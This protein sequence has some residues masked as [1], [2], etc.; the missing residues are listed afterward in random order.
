MS[1]VDGLP[2]PDAMLDPTATPA[3]GATAF[4]ERAAALRA[5]VG[6]A[7]GDAA[8]LVAQLSDDEL[9]GLLDGDAG[10]WAGG[11]RMGLRGY[12]AEPIVAGAVP[13]LGIPGIRFTDGPR[14]IVMG[15]STCF[16]VAIARGATWDPDLEEE[17]GR[18]IGAEGRAQGANFFGGVCINL[19]RHPAWGRAQETYGEDTYHLGVMGSALARGVGTEL[20]ACAKHFALNSIECARFVVDVEADERS[21][22][23]VYLPHFRT[24]VESG[25]D[26]V[27]SAY[28]SVNGEWC[29]DSGT[30]LTAILREEWGFEGLVVSDFAF[31]LR[32]PVGSV[33]AGLDLEMPFRQ[34]RARALPAALADGRLDREDVVRCATRIL[35]AQLRY[36][37]RIQ[38]P[39]PAPAVVASG[40]H[41][42]L[43]R[44]AAAQSMVLLRDEEVDGA[45]LLPLDPDRLQRM[46]VLGRLAT[47]R[48]LGDEGSSAVRP[49]SSVTILD[50]IRA[51]FGAATE[52]EHD[53]GDDVGR[54]AALASEAEVAV[55]TVGYGA[56]DEGEAI[57]ARMDGALRT[58]PPPVG[59]G[60]VAR[61]A[62]RLVGWVA[63][64]PRTP[65]GDRRRL[66]LHPEDERLIEAV[67]AANPRTVVVVIGGSAVLMERWRRK[68]AAILLAWYPGMEGGH[69]LVE[70]LAGDSEPGGRLPFV[71]PTDEAHLPHF[72]RDALSITYDRWWG[73]R[74]LDRDGHA[75]AFPLGFGLGYADFTIGSASLEGVD[76]E[77]E[78][79]SVSVEV[80]NAG[81]RRGGV[82]VQVY[83]SRPDGDEPD[84]REL[85]G[86][87]RT[88]AD[89]GERRRLAIDCSLRPLSV[90]DPVTG[91]WSL[92]SGG[93]RLEVGQWCNDPAAVELSA[94]FPRGA[95]SGAAGP[96]VEG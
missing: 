61:L 69:A 10:F 54:A 19:L 57:V 52:V 44:R 41:R 76:V 12:N 88:E 79:G 17:V 18:A 50:G 26:S 37:A 70:V 60:P 68:A 91:G 43:A 22:H 9:L 28:N 23:E 8:E 47:A 78:T 40:A 65:G 55:V 11:I 82:V 59:W 20:M 87:G 16:P 2:Q 74:L 6:T 1:G 58:L 45:P 51:R 85:I 72:D 7:D 29:G 77:A 25:V 89:A 46:V 84:R 81:S 13:R 32:D 67:A 48:N 90:R 38:H 39:P 86:F 30:L 83:A 5:G 73:Q 3:A 4:A 71:I 75:P 95:R 80:A 33:A 27:M 14:G 66:T 56:R 34:Q 64:R 94:T 24:V 92:P 49:P 15:R 31:G 93:V 53:P 36:S 96:E 35:A 21:L 42:R 63:K 62:G